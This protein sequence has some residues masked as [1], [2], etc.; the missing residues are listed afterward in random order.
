MGYQ[1]KKK[2]MITKMKMLFH[3]QDINGVVNKVHISAPEIFVD[4]EKR[5]RSGHV[6]HAL[7]EFAPGK[8]MAKAGEIFRFCNIQWMSF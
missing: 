8:I 4:N 3:E 1:L 5:G 6:G 2:E 7:V